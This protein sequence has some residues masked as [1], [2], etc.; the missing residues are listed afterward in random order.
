[1]LPSTKPRRERGSCDCCPTDDKCEAG[2]LGKK[3]VDLDQLEETVRVEDRRAEP[4]MFAAG[5]CGAN[6]IRGVDAQRFR[7]VLD[8]AAHDDRA[9]GGD[10]TGEN[11]PGAEARFRRAVEH[12]LAQIDHRHE[13]AAV[14]ERAAN[15]RR[16][17]EHPLDVDERKDLYD[18]PGIDRV[19]VVAKAK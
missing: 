3:L 17:A 10:E 16:R 11:E 12:A 8:L 14:V 18:A 2:I 15:A 19:A 13:A 1:S 6:Q 4:G 9:A 7:G 5:Y